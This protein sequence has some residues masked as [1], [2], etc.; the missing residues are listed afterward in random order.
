[1]IPR[2]SKGTVD[3]Q[4]LIELRK[5]FKSCFAQYP[6]VLNHLLSDMG[7]FGP[8]PNDPGAVALR[9]YGVRILEIL[10]AYDED[11]IEKMLLRDVLR[12]P[13]EINE[14]TRQEDI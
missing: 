3:Y 12:Y 9:N 13:I 4:E 11:G 8:I 7:T 14:P 5:R 2:E 6:D 1:M 10:G